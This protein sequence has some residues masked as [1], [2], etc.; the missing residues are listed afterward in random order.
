[1]AL[2]STGFGSAEKWE[3]ALER[4]LNGAEKNGVSKTIAHSFLTYRDIQKSVTGPLFLIPSITSL[5]PIIELFRNAANRVWNRLFCS[6]CVEMPPER[7]SDRNRNAPKV[8]E[9][10]PLTIKCRATK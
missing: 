9:G 5:S 7:R 1:L 6:I 3:D 2:F 4:M 10:S 8:Y